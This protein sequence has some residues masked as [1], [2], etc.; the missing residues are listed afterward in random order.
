MRLASSDAQALRSQ[1]AAALPSQNYVYSLNVYDVANRL[2]AGSFAF[3]PPA[4]VVQ[5]LAEW[6][7]LLV[8]TSDGKA[9]LLSFLDFHI[10]QVLLFTSNTPVRKM[11]SKASQC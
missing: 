8:L 3:P 4:H 11:L 1:S 6:G 9:R 5:V 7:K 2:I 10:T